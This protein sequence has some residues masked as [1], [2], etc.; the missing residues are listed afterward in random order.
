MIL[1]ISIFVVKIISHLRA[2]NGR[3]QDAITCCMIS[4]PASLSLQDPKEHQRF[5]SFA[6]RIHSTHS[7]PHVI[8]LACLRVETKIA[9]LIR[10]MHFRKVPLRMEH[11]HRKQ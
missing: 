2:L 1:V 7:E 10:Q 6:H 4:A 3:K 5:T 11:S 9:R 8:Y